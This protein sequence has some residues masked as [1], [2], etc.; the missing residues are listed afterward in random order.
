MLAEEIDIYHESIS[1]FE[2]TRRKWFSSCSERGVSL[3]VQTGGEQPHA[4]WWQLLDKVARFQRQE[5][6][7]DQR[8]EDL[9]FRRERPLQRS[10]WHK[11]GLKTAHP[12]VW[13]WHI[14]WNNIWLK[15]FQWELVTTY[16]REFSKMLDRRAF[17]KFEKTLSSKSDKKITFHFFSGVWVCVCVC[18][19]DGQ[20]HT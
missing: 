3:G 18:V 1:P 8:K 15:S 6:H 13:I 19:S 12:E 2:K 10:L 20:S 9:R 5:I 11:P 4:S 16:H 17:S 7:N 14:D